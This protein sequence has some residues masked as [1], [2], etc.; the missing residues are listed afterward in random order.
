M[1]Q[2]PQVGGRWSNHDGVVMA[3]FYRRSDGSFQSF[4]GYGT[5]AMDETTW[6]YEY[7]R[8]RDGARGERCRRRGLG[9]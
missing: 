7:E 1:L 5:Y 9:S 8:V 2:P 3:T 6:S 4:A